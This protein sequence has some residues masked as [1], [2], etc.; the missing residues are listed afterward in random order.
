MFTEFD[1][2]SWAKAINTND[3]LSPEGWTMSRL[4]TSKQACT[5]MPPLPRNL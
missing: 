1:I 5:S 3:E 4:A 2:H